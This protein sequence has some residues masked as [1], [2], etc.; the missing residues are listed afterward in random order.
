MFYIFTF[1]GSY[2]RLTRTFRIRLV[3]D[4][5]KA[6]Y[7]TSKKSANTWLPYIKHNYPQ[8][9]LVEATLTIKK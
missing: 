2:I 5:T 7:W 3:K 8:F 4:I 1:K 6:N 9:N